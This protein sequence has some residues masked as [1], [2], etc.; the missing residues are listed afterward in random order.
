MNANKRVLQLVMYS[1]GLF[2]ILSLLAILNNWSWMPF[3]RINLL[4]E[5]V[6]ESESP[7]APDSI[8]KD[9][10]L[11]DSN[12][13]NVPHAEFDLFRR[14]GYITHFYSDTQRSSL[15]NL[16]ARLHQLKK[17]GKGK[18]RIAY[19]G[20]SMIEGDLMTQTLRRLLQEQFGGEG[21]GFVPITSQIA[22]F[23]T[24]VNTAFSKGWTDEN[25]KEGDTRRLY[26]SGHV[27]RTGNDWVTM[28]DQTI[29]HTDIPVQKSL[30]CG[31]YN[32]EIAINV[33]QARF[34]IH[35]TKLVNRIVLQEDLRKTI[36]L[37]VAT[38][39]LPVY[40]IS[41]ESENGVFVDNFSFRGISGIELA[42]LDSVFLKAIASENPYD[43]IVFQYGVNLLF[44]PKDK[45][46]GWYADIMKPIIQRFSRAFAPAEVVLVSTADRAFRQAG[47]YQTTVG[48]DSL[49]QTQ[50]RMAAEAGIRFYNQFA[51]MGGRNSIV[52]WAKA[53]PSLANQDHVHPN[54]RGAEIL[55]THFYDAIMKEYQKFVNTLKE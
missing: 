53:K 27:F 26:L 24:T 52:A 4:S 10:K 20:D 1:V 55:A 23:R 34:P 22:H 21:V 48:V 14:P 45:Q 7:A 51:S 39:Q 2:L 12:V 40:G 19:F 18:I 41:F 15:P 8:E 42:R 31:P 3:S 11:V 13:V 30:L 33:N 49:V 44:R 36:A 35:P 5:I 37:G 50:A 9:K 29:R 32:K 28:S 46:F 16:A 25:F 43:L 54:A 17:S 38:P 6:R 47:I